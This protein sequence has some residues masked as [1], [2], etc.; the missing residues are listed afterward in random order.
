MLGRI[1]YVQ[2]SE[3]RQQCRHDYNSIPSA[4]QSEARAAAT[5]A[6]LDAFSAAAAAAAATAKT[7]PPAQRIVREEHVHPAAAAR[8][9]HIQCYAGQQ[10]GPFR[11][12]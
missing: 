5:V 11:V 1:L 2:S 10:E 3:D 6:Q 4:V 8:V 9:D 7:P 12:G